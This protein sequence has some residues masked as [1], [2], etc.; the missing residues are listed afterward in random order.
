MAFSEE[1][2]SMARQLLLSWRPMNSSRRNVRGFT[3]VELAVVVVIVG[4]L[5]IIAVVAY[6][7]IVLSSKLNEA[8]SMIGAIMIAQEEYRAERGQFKDIAGAYCPSDGA[9]CKK[10][11]WNNLCGTP[12]GWAT[13]PVHAD[14]AVQ[15][16]YAT[17]AGTVV[18]QP[19]GVNANLIDLGGYVGKSMP[20]FVVHAKADLDCPIG[21][22]VY[23]ELAASSFDKEIRS[24]NVGE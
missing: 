23:S 19:A 16:G 11:G 18:A 12:N 2:H 13:L 20:Y 21:N 1:V 3:L 24:I 9:Q 4:L 10:Y 6:R 8:R 5:S 7:K 22:G 15:F 17:F 14:N